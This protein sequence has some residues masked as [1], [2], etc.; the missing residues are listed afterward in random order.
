VFEVRLQAQQATHGNAQVASGAA[1][2]QAAPKGSSV[3][4]E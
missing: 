1:E 3:K 4:K 2:I